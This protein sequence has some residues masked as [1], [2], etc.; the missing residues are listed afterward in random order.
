MLRISKTS[1]IVESMSLFFVPR[2]RRQREKTLF[3]ALEQM[4]FMKAL[5]ETIVVAAWKPEGCALG[6]LILTKGQWA[7]CPED[8]CSLFQGPASLEK[9]TTSLHSSV[10]SL[11]EWKTQC[12]HQPFHRF[13]EQ[14]TKLMAT[15]RLAIYQYGRPRQEDC[16]EFG[17]KL[18]LKVRLCL[19]QTE[20][21]K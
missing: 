4:V 8:R 12:K 16:F 6:H 11:E 10:F 15:H 9:V 2:A 20:R 17:V 14:C 18:G 7:K 19:T 1:W 3:M 5:R 21:R 13:G